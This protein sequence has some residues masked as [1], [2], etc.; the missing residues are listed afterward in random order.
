[1]VESGM[2]VDLRTRWNLCVLN[3]LNIFG[4]IFFIDYFL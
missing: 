3:V 1:V 2:D 4:F